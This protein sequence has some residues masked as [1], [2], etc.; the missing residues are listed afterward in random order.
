[1]K[2]LEN[3]LMFNDPEGDKRRAEEAAEAKRKADLAKLD[4]FLEPM[5]AL[6]EEL[7]GREKFDKDM[8]K[9]RKRYPNLGEGDFGHITKIDTQ[10]KAA[11]DYL[12]EI[13]AELP[14]FEEVSAKWLHF[15]QEEIKRLTGL[16][17][18]AKV[19]ADAKREEDKKKSEL[20]MWQS[21]GSQF[22]LGDKRPRA[23][24]LLMEQYEEAKGKINKMGTYQNAT[25][26]AGGGQEYA[27]A[28][29]RMREVEAINLDK[30]RNKKLQ[31]LENVTRQEIRKQTKALS[32]ALNGQEKFQGI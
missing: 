2:R 19:A 17:D 32:E 6:G 4:E 16:N 25:T 7:K 12:N 8:E 23:L 13:N 24:Q 27:L 11:L 21:A 20:G 31:S 15:Q 26:V 28:A 18:A 14:L 30:E 22:G 5:K 10:R 1:M 9:M 29:Q 3:Q